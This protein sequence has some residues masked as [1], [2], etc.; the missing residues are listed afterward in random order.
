MLADLDLVVP[1]EPDDPLA[2]NGIGGMAVTLVLVLLG[3][4]LGM[5]IDRA[6]R[7]SAMAVVPLLVAAGG[8]SVLA[9]DVLGSR[10][11]GHAVAVLTAT[12]VLT[13]MA[14]V[15]R[16]TC[17]PAIAGR[18]RLVS[19]NALLSVVPLVLALCLVPVLS[20]LD[21]LADVAIPLLTATM[22]AGA[23]LLFRMV[24]AAQEPAP[25]RVG[26]RREMAEAIRF[27]ARH[28]VL[29]AI[30]LYLVVSALVAEFADEVADGALRVA[31]E[32]AGIPVGSYFSMVNLSALSAPFVGALLAV[33]LHRKVGVF[34][35][36]CAALLV[37]EPFTLLLALSGSPGATIWYVVGTLVPITGTAVA[38]LTLLSHLQALT[39]DRLL[40]RVGGLLLA[41]TTLADALG[42]LLATPAE[43][44]ADATPL[45]S[46]PGPTLATLAA[47]AATVPLLRAVA[48]HLR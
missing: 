14:P 3:L 4:P 47:L 13:A 17:L 19:A 10:S 20:L 24:D 33:L 23:A 16:D 46:L 5:L 26:S 1:L 34:R 31:A 42:G 21:D 30:A 7:R 28:P 39:P 8:L 27:T 22:A 40:G 48:A 35:L 36:A 18:E 11:D 25:P 6:R 44:L 37:S 43:R 12:G 41:L 38:A 29:R 15:V 9:A 45:T 32:S 2:V